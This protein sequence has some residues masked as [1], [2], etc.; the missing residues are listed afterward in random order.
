M[1]FA[2][3]PR[4]VAGCAAALSAVLATPAVAQT[5]ETLYRAC[6]SSGLSEQPGGDR[7]IATARATK[8][9]I[10]DHMVKL[11]LKLQDFL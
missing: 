8:A 2:A 6:Y 5:Y 7:D 9:D 3:F 10:D 4:G 11:G 1:R